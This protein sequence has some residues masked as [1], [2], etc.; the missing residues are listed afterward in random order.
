MIDNKTN[1]IGKLYP[2]MDFNKAFLS[3]DTLEGALCQTTG[4]RISQKQAAIDAVR[5]IGLNQLSEVDRAWFGDGRIADM[6]F[7]RLDVLKDIDRER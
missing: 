6:F 1:K 4:K 3:Y 5:T 7:A 2:L